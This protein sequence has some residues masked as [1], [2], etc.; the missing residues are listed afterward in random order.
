VT[1]RPTW[2]SVATH[3]VP[4]WYEDAKLGVFVHWGPYSVP[5]WAPRVPD[6]QTVL[7]DHGPSWLLRHNPYAEW[8][9]NSAGLKGSSTWRHHQETYGA[10]FSYD[11]FV[12]RFEAASGAADLGELAGL[13]RAAGARYVVLTAKHADG[14]CLW[15][16]S[17]VHPVKGAYRSG[18]D[19]VGDLSA[20]VRAAGMRMGLYY[21]G[22]YD[23]PFNGAV[24]SGLADLALAVPADPA[25]AR[26]A[27]V[28]VAELVERYRPSVLWN[29]VGWP[30]G[31]DLA[32]LFA[33]YYNSVEDGVLNDRWFQTGRRRRATDAVLRAAAAVVERLWPLVPRRRRALVIPQGRHFDFATPE[34]TAF[35][36]IVE[37]KWEATRG[38]GN[39]FGANRNED[40]AAALSATGLIRL[41][42]DVV[43]K[44]G[45][46]LIGVGPEPDGEVPEWQ[47]EPLRGL[48]RWLAVNG[49]AIYG[50]RPWSAAAAVTADDTPVRHTQDGRALYLTLLGTP[51]TTKV[52]FPSLEVAG[53]AADAL[54]V[55]LLGSE[56]RI[57][58]HLEGGRL[59]VDLPG[60]LPVSESPVLKVTPLA[61]CRAAPPG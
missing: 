52:V 17:Q 16:T 47:A 42:A 59:A 60:R 6:I 15:P 31:S 18:R 22:G 50:T 57:E 41:L 53:D 35:D 40:P 12:P 23:W 9:R 38:V 13:C 10:D 5:A 21:C 24:L 48:G 39:S 29:D 44:N 49:E 8:Y 30:P 33:D 2:E 36:D 11:G 46:L 37:K 4:A 28:H 43:A 3:P 32:A 25:Y 55:G 51:G 61:A 56:G 54:R 14:Y 27:E 1:Y 7:R 58:H 26:Y 20:A 45:N 19:L 34:Y